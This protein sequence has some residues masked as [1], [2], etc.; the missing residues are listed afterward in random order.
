MFNKVCLFT[1]KHSFVPPVTVPVMIKFLEATF[2]A[3][4]VDP[5]CLV[6]LLV[7]WLMFT[8]SNT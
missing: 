7:V 4:T 5:T 2:V 1:S 6:V 8:L 3:V